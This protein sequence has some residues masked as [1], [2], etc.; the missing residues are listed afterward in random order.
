MS[1]WVSVEEHSLQGVLE[2][3]CSVLTLHRSTWCFITY[4]LSLNQHKWLNKYRQQ[5][6]VQH[7][8]LANLNHHA[9][10]RPRDRLALL[11]HKLNPLCWIPISLTLLLSVECLLSTSHRTDSKQLQITW[12]DVHCNQCKEW[13]HLDFQGNPGVVKTNSEIRQYSAFCSDFFIGRITGIICN[14]IHVA[15][16]IGPN[17]FITTLVHL[18]VYS[19]Y[20][21]KGK[22]HYELWCKVF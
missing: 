18:I 4:S 13:N 5:S 10:T 15:G 20:E 19:V 7:V 11:V 8:F 6:S 21:K 22:K 16:I 12:C 3:C 17:I 2:C 9:W 14:L 1:K